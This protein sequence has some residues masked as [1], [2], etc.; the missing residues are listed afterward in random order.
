[1]DVTTD[2]VLVKNLYKLKL[3]FGD[4]FDKEKAINKDEVTELGY[5]KK[6]KVR[7]HFAGRPSVIDVAKLKAFPEGEEAP[8]KAKYKQNRKRRRKKPGRKKGP[9][10]KKLLP[11][12]RR[13][14][15]THREQR[16]RAALERKIKARLAKRKERLKK[17]EQKSVEES[18]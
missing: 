6:I 8:T 11:K 3:R 18:V 2:E 7:R 16:E 1:M 5:I 13:G 10:L 12:R 9:T 15:P 14:R 17:R 4:S